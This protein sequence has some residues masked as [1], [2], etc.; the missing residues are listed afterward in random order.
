MKKNRDISKIDSY[1]DFL[2]DNT[3]KSYKEYEEPAAILDKQIK[4][5]NVNNIAIVAKYGA[6]KSCL[7]KTYLDKY[8]K[9]KTF[10]QKL[11]FNKRQYVTSN[12]NKYVK[13]S[14]ST[15]NDND[16]DETSIERSI[17]QQLL[18]SRKK[19][20]FPNSKI[21]RTNRT[22]ILRVIAVSAILTIMISAFIMLG[23]D[24]SKA[25]FGNDCLK[26]VFLGIGIFTF[27]INTILL[28]YYRKLK[29]IKYKDLE[30]DLTAKNE[31]LS[32]QNKNLINKFIDEVLYFFD[33]TNVDLVIFED[34]DRLQSTEI[35]VKLR[36]LNTIINNSR[37]KYGKV[38]FI[39]A[40]K[41]DLFKTEEERAKFFDFILPVIPVINPITTNKIIEDVVQ[42]LVAYNTSMKLSS[43]FIKGISLYIPD[44]RILNNTFNDYII[45]FRKIMEDEK[46]SKY[47]ES[48]K[49]FALCL[50][51]NLFPYDYA[52]L[53][54]NQGLIPKVINID[55][56][57]IK[58]ADSVERKIKEIN[59]RIEN[60]KNE[61]LNRFEELKMVLEMQMQK[62]SYANTY[63][64]DFKNISSI[65]TFDGI[66][67]NNLSHPKHPGYLIQHDHYENDIVDLNG[68]KY[69]DREKQIKDK[70]QHNLE[71]LKTILAQLEKEKN[72]IFNYTIQDIVNKE[73]VDF[74]VNNSIINSYEL[75]L[76]S[77]LKNQ[78]DNLFGALKQI[79]KFNIEDLKSIGEKFSS[80][81]EEFFPKDKLNQQISYLRYLLANNYID[82][83]YLEYTSTYQTNILSL[84]DI[85]VAQKIQSGACQFDVKI[86][87]VLN[88]VKWLNDDDFKKESIIIKDL[89][90]EIENIRKLSEQE[91]DRKFA[92]LI[93]LL[94]DINKINVL[95]KLNDFIMTINTSENEGLL[96]YLIPKRPTLLAELIDIGD[97]DYEKI[98][99]LL[100]KTIKY[101]S[102]YQNVDFARLVAKYLSEHNEYLNSLHLHVGPT[103]TKKFISD[104]SPKFKDIGVVNNYNEILDYVIVND[105]Y[106]ISLGN[107]RKILVESCGYTERDFYNMNYS[108]ICNSENKNLITY[109]NN[110]INDYVKE[111]LLNLDI[112][113][114]DEEYEKIT[115][116][117]KNELLDVS[118]KENLITKM[119]CMVLDVSEFDEKLFKSLFETQHVK[120]TWQNI[121]FAFS[122]QGF[123]CVSNFIKL[124]DNIEGEFGRIDKTNLDLINEI[125][126]NS[127]V[128]KIS[129]ILSGLTEKIN[130]NQICVE[131]IND[132]VLA[133]VIKLNKINYS[134]SDFSLLINHDCVLEE[135]IRV[136][137]DNIVSNF[138]VFF[139]IILPT[140]HQEYTNRGH[141]IIFIPK[142]KSQFG[143]AQILNLNNI[144]IKIKQELLSKCSK[145]IDIKDNELIYANYCINE[146]QSLPTCVLWQ[147]TD[148]CDVIP[149]C[150]R[151]KI[152]LQCYNEIDWAK[153]KNNFN[154]YISALGNEWKNIFEKNEGRVENNEAHRYLL[155]KLKNQNII[156]SFRR[157]SAQIIVKR[158]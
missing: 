128:Q 75:E 95:I 64:H 16:L 88:L 55:E 106:S 125:L 2:I 39:Y 134:N 140:S 150:D 19:E 26:Y 112:S 91:K 116:L 139:N 44:M 25:M 15:Y 71:N 108:L 132:N 127:T 69:I 124:V 37:K 94:S 73:S 60:T 20:K 5:E 154:N 87:N 6:G 123:G 59:T 121:Q 42:K 28:I 90:L 157:Q 136:Y 89:L 114:Q 62:R 47:L 31:V 30:A 104:I 57:R 66:T 76:N 129:D 40:V 115:S 18:Y 113:L 120:P 138:N 100:I 7:I 80:I 27:F 144:D 74:C 130:L 147:F 158:A 23:L 84:S 141:E 126:K 143:I 145:I 35:F 70:E 148:A 46:A 118:L 117:L 99:N 86:D 122:K 155:E 29:K 109:I 110:N 58:C 22:P 54:K 56:L 152:L 50:Y 78:K 102:E 103:A 82:E 151:V 4:I 41:D 9:K 133:E 107:L 14:L 97:L 156:K 49:L 8:R 1:Y 142:E 137:F 83:H 81:Y 111:V 51:K 3:A 153:E 96:K 105:Y 63:S 13:V 68:V 119:Q 135:Y 79:D 24:L 11:G 72:I 85:K 17:L 43:N 52:L 53:E 48:N 21:E 32:V 92:N 67:Y 45:M 77:L 34:L 36:E 38:T 61:A 65:N 98:D 149:A 33:C 131:E 12:K 101:I 93:N 10:L 146:K